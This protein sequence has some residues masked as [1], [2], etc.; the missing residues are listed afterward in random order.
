MYDQDIASDEPDDL[1]ADGFERIE[2]K[3]DSGIRYVYYK[4][5]LRCPHCQLDVTLRPEA[6]DQVVRDLIRSGVSSVEL[7]T[8]AKYAS[9][10]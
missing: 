10:Q 3:G 6:A 2:A 4:L 1:L 9:R 7:S 5:R 8:L